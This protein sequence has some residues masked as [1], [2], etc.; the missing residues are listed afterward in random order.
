MSISSRHAD[1]FYMQLRG[2]LRV[3]ESASKL[4][5]PKKNLSGTRNLHAIVI[6]GLR[7]D[8]FRANRYATP[9]VPVEWKT[10]R[11]AYD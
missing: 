3:T 10:W 11:L 2:A 5:V 7:D 6:N 8:G 1:G 9:P 4:I